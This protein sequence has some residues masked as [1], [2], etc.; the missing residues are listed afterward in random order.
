MIEQVK[1]ELFDGGALVR[2]IFERDKGNVLSGALMKQLDAALTEH[3]NDSRLKL[4]TLE[5][6]GKHFS[7]GASVE[8]HQRDQ[9]PEMLATF[10]ALIRRMVRYPVPI[11][12]VVRGRCLGGAFEVA[13][14]SRF[15]FADPGAVF[16]CPEIKL[17][18][19]PPVLAAL[20]PSRLGATWTERL[21]LT[22]AELDARAAHG[23]GFVTELVPDGTDAFE[24]ARGWYEK[25]LAELSAF[26]IRQ[27]VEALRRGSRQIEAA[28]DAL[29][30]IERQYLERVVPS[31]DGNEGIAAFLE[32]RKPRWT[33][34]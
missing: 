15:V 7:F 33:D 27:G 14:A 12:A 29:A 34:A 1:S 32:K 9:A 22:G 20:G 17:G 25:G 10:H 23:L 5:G 26:A 6:A 31:H 16:A 18:V 4:V 3:A 11:A 30:T 8:E 2:V 21:L 19:L 13:L 24:H 28:G